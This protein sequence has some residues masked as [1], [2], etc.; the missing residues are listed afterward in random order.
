MYG[1]DN[2]D[3]HRYVYLL[4]F[5]GRRVY[6]GQSVDPLR[7]L[8]AHRRPSGGWAEPFLPVIAHRVMGPEIEVVRLEYAW[9]WCAYCHG[10]TPIGLDGGPYDMAHLRDD[11]KQRGAELSWP[12]TT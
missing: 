10:W 1:W 3:R 11:A 4:A 5:A 9:R 12:F 6:V 7:R 2:E 8:K